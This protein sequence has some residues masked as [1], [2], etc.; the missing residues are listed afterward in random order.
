MIK[1]F[2]QT[3]ELKVLSPKTTAVSIGLAF[4]VLYT[5]IPVVIGSVAVP[6]A[7][8]LLVLWLCR[9]H[10]INC[11]HAVLPLVVILCTASV[12][13]VYLSH[14]EPSSSK[15][16]SS[17]AQMIYAAFLSMV[18]Y[19][20]IVHCSYF[21]LKRIYAVLFYLAFALLLLEYF[22]VTS[23]ITQ[24]FGDLFYGKSVG[25]EFYGASEYALTRD[26]E[27]SG[28]RRPTLFSPEPSIAAI[29]ISVVCVLFAMT[30]NNWYYKLLAY[31]CLVISWY[32]FGSPI[33]L[34]FLLVYIINAVFR[35]DSYYLSN[36]FRLSISRGF[37]AI[38]ISP[39]IL[40]YGSVRFEKILF[41]PILIYTSSEGIRG[42]LPFINAY[43]AIVRDSFF[44]AGPGSVSDYLYVAS[45]N[46]YW[47]EAFG[48][49]T[50]A[51]LLFY[52]GPVQLILIVMIYKYSIDYLSGREGGPSGLTLLLYSQAV[53]FS[54]GAIESI[55]T[56]GLL[57]FLLSTATVCGK[58][59]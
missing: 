29:G 17:L 37:F 26:I 3:D 7:L 45:L 39:I 8:S 52:F 58:I 43:T 22:N 15:I 32:I 47:S 24:K 59:K 28:G 16:A 54:L 11:A 48:T 41:D 33:P 20:T 53:F 42:I 6:G 31:I 34:L 50:T 36:G 9:R 35:N 13:S 19:S 49:N 55:R 18:I 46:E 5:D 1:I 14:A 10:V 38:I 2:S 25:F 44:G 57:A 40:Y 4:I 12:V 23:G 21:V 51:E 56:L 30:N 27:I